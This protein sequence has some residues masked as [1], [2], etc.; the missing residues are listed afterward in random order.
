MIKIGQ[1]YKSENVGGRY[2]LAQVDFG[3]VALI[4]LVSGNLWEDP[5]T[6]VNN[7]KITPEEWEKI[8]GK[9]LKADCEYHLYEFELIEV[10]I[11]EKQPTT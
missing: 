11:K 3:K 2:L 9:E 7:Y 8:R 4:D 1:Y 10:E 5:A 6:V